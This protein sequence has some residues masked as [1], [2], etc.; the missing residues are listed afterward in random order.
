MTTWD[1]MATVAVFLA[2]HL[3]IRWRL[4]K[5]ERMRTDLRRR[6]RA[7]MVTRGE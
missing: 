1:L 4:R 3:A 6:L 7:G 2:I 5:L